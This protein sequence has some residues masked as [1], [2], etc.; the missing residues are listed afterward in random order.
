ML[1]NADSIAVDRYKLNEQGT[2]ELYSYEQGDEIHL[3]CIDFILPVSLLYEDV[4]LDTPPT[5]KSE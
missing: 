4:D 1:C 5:P 3:E 2:W